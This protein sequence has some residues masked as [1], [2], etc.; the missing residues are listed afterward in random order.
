M[1]QPKKKIDSDFTI[2]KVLNLTN[3]NDHDPSVKQV[4]FFLNSVGP[5]TI[6]GKES[7]DA[8]YTVTT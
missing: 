1:A 3:N 5:A 8:A 4:P 6:R 7:G 2:N